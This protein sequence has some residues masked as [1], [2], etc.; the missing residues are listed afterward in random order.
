MEIFD[1]ASQSDQDAVN[2]L[3]RLLKAPGWNGMALDNPGK[4]DFSHYGQSSELANILQKKEYGFFIEA[5]AGDG[6]NGSVSL[7]F[8]RDMKWYGLLVEDDYDTFLELQEK[9]RNSFTLHAKLSTTGRMRLIKTS[10]RFVWIDPSN[11]HWE[12]PLY[13][14]FEAMGNTEVDLL[15]LD[16]TGTELE[17]LRTLP[18]DSVKISVMCI[19]YTHIP[20]NPRSLPDY[21]SLKGYT[22]LKTHVKDM[23]FA[24]NEFLQ[25]QKGNTRR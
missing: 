20:G 3:S 18:W 1:G 5:H 15:I 17:I 25:R 21:L 13:S 19:A 16:T 4:K 23:F 14:L 7:L 6:E 10:R 24:S 12:I 11:S 22:L 2:S 8:E 9:G